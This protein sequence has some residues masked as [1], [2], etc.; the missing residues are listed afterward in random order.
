M[1]ETELTNEEML[2]RISRTKKVLLSTVKEH[3]LGYLS[4]INEGREVQAIKT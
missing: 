4:H 2:H 3:E 1:L